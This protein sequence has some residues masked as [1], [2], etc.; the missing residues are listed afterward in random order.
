M[1]HR[2][3]NEVHNATALETLA[4]IHN[5][6]VT[7]IY[8]D[9]PFGTNTTQASSR[10]I[11]G[12]SSKMSYSDRFE[13]YLDFFV[14]HLSEFKR[15]LAPHGTLY[16]HLDWRWVHYVKVEADKV[17][18]RENFVSEIIWSYNFGGRGKKKWPAKHDTILMYAKDDSKRLFNWDDVDRIP[19]KAPELQY[20]GR[21]KADAESRIARGQVPTDVWDMS[22]IGTASKERVGYPNQ[23][24][25]ALV[26]R[27][28]K[29]SSRVDDLVVDPFVGSGTTAVAASELGRRFVVG[30]VSRDA[31]ATT[32]KRLKKEDNDEH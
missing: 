5:D 11:D 20:V 12:I 24:P 32:K 17:F 10:T 9:P 4:R 21:T 29:A 26:K 6:E 16:L 15:I 23:K 2:T 22:I 19:Y 18:G 1:F 28:L 14:P 7:L 27:I 31:V 8:T 30:D 3:D 13:D 25:L